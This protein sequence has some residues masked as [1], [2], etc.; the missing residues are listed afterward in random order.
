[1]NCNFRV[2]PQGS[3][4]GTWLQESVARVDVYMEVGL[5]VIQLTWSVGPHRRGLRTHNDH[6]N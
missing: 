3:V 6:P 5:L 2:E 4:W 1:M